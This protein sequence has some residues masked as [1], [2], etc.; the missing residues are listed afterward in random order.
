V[1]LVGEAVADGPEPFD[2]DHLRNFKLQRILTTPD[3]YI[4]ALA[5]QTDVSVFSLS[6]S[7]TKL[8]IVV[9]SARASFCTRSMDGVR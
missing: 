8:A 7:A 2:R 6:S 5:S 9:P 1:W 3:P 4:R